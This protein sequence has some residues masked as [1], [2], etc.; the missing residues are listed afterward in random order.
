MAAD[1]PLTPPQ[2]VVESGD[3]IHLPAAAARVSA[4]STPGPLDPA[5]WQLLAPGAVVHDVPA[6][7][8]ARQ[9]LARYLRTLPGGTTVVLRSARLRSRRHCRRLARD[10]GIELVHEYVAVPSLEPPT[11]FVEDAPAVFRYFV[12]HVLAL[13]DGGPAASAALETV[14]LIPGSFVPLG[15]VGSLAPKR[16]ALGRIPVS[17]SMPALDHAPGANDLG[18]LDLPGMRALV[19]AF[20]KDPNAKL[21]VL[22]FPP[23]SPRPTLAVK[24]P[25]TALAEA[26]IAAERDVLSK[27]RLGLPDAI[28]ASIPKLEDLPALAGRPSLVATALP[29]VPMTTRYHAWR[30]ISSPKGARAD[31]GAAERW[32]AGFQGATARPRKPVDL[33]GGLPDVLRRRFAAEPH[34]VELL[35]TLSEIHA[36]LRATSTPRTA[37]HGDFWFG[38]LLW[39]G[40]EISGVVDWEHG[41]LTGEPVRDLVRFPLAYALYLDRHTRAGR[42]VGGHPALQAGVWGSGIT[43]ALDGEGWFPDL[44]RDFVRAGLTRLGADAGCWR[45]AMLAGVA[46]VA[47]TADHLDFARLHWRLFERLTE[48]STL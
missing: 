12:S 30:H 10:A 19:L 32:L 45:D 11:C 27:V 14:K 22:L 8:L 5:I 34:L 37:V 26:S 3:S 18:L 6:T 31:F 40:G 24:V 7:A 41:A 23:D 13:P 28:Q 35:S 46:E 17:S 36:R 44:V 43:Y 20:S 2:P 9:R 38:N 39:D 21:T 47:A 16:L 42:R 29:G 15:L 4:E 48:R 25:T 33:E 1:A